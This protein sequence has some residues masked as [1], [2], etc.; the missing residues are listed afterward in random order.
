MLED[1]ERSEKNLFLKQIFYDKIA[2]IKILSWGVPAVAPWIKNPTAG[3]HSGHC[4][5]SFNSE[6]KD[7]V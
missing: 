5:G 4:R 1:K 2:R 7:L 6:L 3:A